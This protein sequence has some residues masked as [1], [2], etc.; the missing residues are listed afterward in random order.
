MLYVTVNIALIHA[1]CDGKRVKSVP[2]KQKRK[3]IASIIT[4]AHHRPCEG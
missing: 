2:E 3:K 1:A 4:Q